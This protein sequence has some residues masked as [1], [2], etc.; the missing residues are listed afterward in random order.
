MDKKVLRVSQR[1][2]ACAIV[3]ASLAACAGM[4]TLPESK[5]QETAAAV[6]G[7][8]VTAVS[9]VRSVND[10]QYFD[11]RVGDGTVYACSL[12]VVFGVTSQKQRCEKK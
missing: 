7:K 2:A 5:L 3:C 11:A 4:T 12:Q 10:M 8:P 6:I 1:T 9:N